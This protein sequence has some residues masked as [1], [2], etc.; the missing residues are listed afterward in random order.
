MPTDKTTGKQMYFTVGGTNVKLTKAT[1]KVDPKFADTTDG[2]DYDAA[3]DLIYPTQI[4][5]S[6]PV[7]ISVEGFYYKSQTPSAVVAKLFT[8]GGP[9]ALTFGPATGQAHF[10]GN[11][12]LSGFQIDSELMDTVKWSA[13]LKSNGKITPNS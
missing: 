8:G 12:D 11:Y 7:E 4:Q 13:T 3:T 9:Y 6:A 2:G 1:P 10:S 5:V